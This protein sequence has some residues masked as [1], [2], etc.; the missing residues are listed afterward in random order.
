MKRSLLMV[1][2]LMAAMQMYGAAERPN[3]LVILLDDAGWK[4]VGFSGSTFA[5]TPNIDRLASQG[6]V[7]PTAYSTHPFCAPARQSLI[8]GQWPARTAWMQRFE[9]SNP[10]APHGAPPYAAAGAYAWTHRRPEFVSIAE[11]LKG[12]GYATAHIGKWHF[13]IHAHDISPES[14]GF[15]LNF[16]GDNMVGAVKNFFA[17]Y[18]GLPGNVKAPEGEYL[19]DRLTQETIDFIREHKEDP[20]YIQLWHYAPHTPIMAP[21]SVVKKYRR[22]REQLGDMSLNPTYAAMID[23]VDQGV[24]RIFQTLEKLGLADNTVI[25]FTSDNGGVE[26]LG[27][28][29][30][31]SMAPF[32]DEKGFMYQGGVREPMFIRWPGVTTGSVCAETVS[33]IDFYPTILDLADVPFPEQPVDGVSLV[34]LL[35]NRPLPSLSDRPLFWHNVTTGLKADGEFYQPVAS[36]LKGKWRVVKNF[37]RPL[38]LYNLTDDPG[39]SENLAASRPEKTAELEQLLDEWLADT[40]VVTP[41]K[42]P[43]YEP[44]YV[45]PRQVDS[46]PEGAEVSKVWKLDDSSCGWSA[47]RM[48][49][50]SFVDGAMRLQADGVY[51]VIKSEA[52]SGLPAGRYVVQLELKVPTS[53]RIRF[54]WG[55][56][57]VV[58][59]FP[60]RDGEWHTL[61]GLFEAKEPISELQLAAPT[62]LNTTGHY[63]PATQPE[64]IEVRSIKL[65]SLLPVSAAKAAIL[66]TDFQPAPDAVVF[67]DFNRADVGPDWKCDTGD[68]WNVLKG[69]LV[70][71]RSKGT[72]VPVLYHTQ[73]EAGSGAEASVTV[74]LNV[75]NRTA[76]AGIVTHYQNPTDQYVF[77][78]SGEGTVQ[79]LVK[80]AGRAILTRQNAFLH[81]PGK[82]YRLTVFEPAPHQFELKVED[83]EAGKTVFSET[84]T[85]PAGL[86]QGGFFGLYNSAASVSFDD[87]Q[88]SELKNE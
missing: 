4:D 26:S 42:N 20:F 7:F 77:R 40:G 87:F 37:G 64:W 55:E 63:D 31:T 21:E 84:V 70:P 85:D 16:G 82:P 1:T 67:D 73:A 29:P 46:L 34:P 79:F 60:Q 18:E 47:A 6:L 13:G 9:V 66:K 83:V 45:I 3:F 44:D 71:E 19:T 80:N 22:K 52:L 25:L 28:V 41:T 48:I 17:P 33:L 36:V 72:P 81:V 53:G 43:F 65:F 78:F 50:T 74:R 49:K 30:V 10:D 14:E 15:D 61:T 38:E 5:E 35:K 56:R 39:E 51:P 54:I 59:F 69:L 68:G 86:Y 57:D 58:E 11:A 24:G 75:P 27:S 32:R 12:A 2:A 23:V 88:L 8:S 62:H 76:F